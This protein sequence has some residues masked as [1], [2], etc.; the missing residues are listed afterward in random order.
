MSRILLSLF[1][2]AGVFASRAEPSTAPEKTSDGVILTFP[3]Y[4][5]KIQ[6]RTPGIVRVAAAPDRSFFQR[7]SMIVVPHR[8]PAPA[9]KL[10][11]DA[12]NA[13]IQT[14]QIQV[15]INRETGRIQFCDAAGNVVLAERQH[16]RSLSSAEVLGQRVL[17][18]RQQ[19]DPAASEGLYGLG[20]NQTGLLN[21][22]GRDMDYWQRNTEVFV[23]FLV[24]SRGFG[25]LWDN[26]S[27]T[28]FGDLRQP[29]LLP[30]S[31]LADATGKAGGLTGT[32]FADAAFSRPVATRVDGQIAFITP[33]GDAATNEPLHPALPNGDV[34]VRW[35]G[36]VEAPE[37]GNYTFQTYSDGG[38]RLWIDDRQV[39][40]HWRQD[41]LPGD[42][43]AQVQLDGG[44]RH[45]I[46]VEWTKDQKA[47]VFRLFWKTPSHDDSISLWSEA[48]DGLD[49]SFVYGPELDQVVAGYREL[50]GAATLMPRWAY[51]LWQ[52]RQRYETSQQLTDV[53]KGFR[54]REIP[55]DVVVQDWF[56]WP[57]DGWGSHEFEKSRFPDPDGWLKDL[58]DNLHT[59]LM[60]SVWGKFYTGTKNFDELNKA[61]FLY[62]PN[63]R[64]GIKDWLGFPFTFYDAFR[65][66]ARRLYWSQVDT[67]LFKRGVDAWWLDATEP[68]LLPTPDL[69]QQ[70]VHIQPAAGNRGLYL[71]NAYALAQSQ[72]VYEG[73]RGSAPDQRVYILTRS[74]FAGQQRYAAATWSGD[75]TSTWTA[76]RKQIAAG[77][78][79]SI[80][81]IPYWTMDIGGFSVPARFSDPKGMTEENA[82]EWREMNT[83]WFQFGAF[84]PIL[85]VH[86]EFPNREMWE[87]GGETSPAYQAM[88]KADRLRYRLMPY[89]YSLAGSVTFHGSTIMRPLVMDFRSDGIA[90]EIVDQFLFGPAFLVS[91][92]TT[93]RARER[94][95]YLP[96]GEWYDFWSGQQIAGQQ[97]ITAAAPYDAIPLHVRAGSIVPMGPELQYTGEKPAEPITLMV[98]AGADGRFT[99]YEDDGLTYGYEK[100]ARSQIPLSWDDAKGVLTIGKRDGEFPGMLKERTFQVVLVDRAHP[101]PFSFE[102][103]PDKTVKYQG[104]PVTVSLR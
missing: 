45:R 2:A 53:V 102:L 6:V 103:K 98:Y 89:I 76:M 3:D 30:A 27:H 10:T 70:R 96:A 44:R 40:N 34:S 97:T 29:E 56:Y 104:S 21:L 9:W 69:D 68:D 8:G 75:I 15:R 50:T 18:V 57:R 92:V 5:L 100:G 42:E 24:S 79:F 77:L 17:Q 80:S 62:Q 91:P 82:E 99:I 78:G 54:Q 22:K 101:V 31:V 35:E 74:G 61:G 37:T 72:A 51:G 11:G 26:T 71:L 38:V 58:H 59:R 67:A 32:Y 7:E 47:H 73:Q 85:R 66:E 60:I 87:F 25:I 48:A 55:F 88:L 41:W 49:Y 1:C 20:Q 4:V 28:R 64:D 94:S 36:F 39:M 13:V 81:G 43:F 19:W 65:P 63:L 46:R 95:V 84:A 14:D 93:Y 52:S 23:P 86:G 33:K 16:G 90:R 12:E 83:R